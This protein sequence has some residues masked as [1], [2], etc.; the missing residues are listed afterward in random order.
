[1]L[2]TLWC[3]GN[4]S[5]TTALEAVRLNISGVTDWVIVKVL[6]DSM[7]CM[8]TKF[9]PVLIFYR[10]FQQPA[11]S[12]N[13]MTKDT[14]QPMHCA[15][16]LQNFILYNQHSFS[17]QKYW[18]CCTVI[19]NSAITAWLIPGNRKW[20]KVQ[21]WKCLFVMHCVVISTNTHTHVLSIQ[22]WTDCE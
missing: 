21:S 7:G 2:K 8:H 16:N 1:M 9:C 10:L 18:S 4:G 14:A 20:E 13:N 19:R 5:Y 22:F 17:W 6:V 12:A 11:T 3:S 15:H